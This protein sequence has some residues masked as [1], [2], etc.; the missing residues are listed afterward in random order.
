MKLM[1]V[2]KRVPVS[3]DVFYCVVDRVNFMTI[4]L[5]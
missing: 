1:G 3:V 4:F 2:A 5:L